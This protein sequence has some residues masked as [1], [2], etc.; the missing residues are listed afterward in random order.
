MRNRAGLKDICILL[1]PNK[2]ILIYSIFLRKIYQDIENTHFLR[3]N[4]RNH[5]VW[6]YITLHYISYMI[7][8]IHIIYILIG[9]VLSLP[10]TFLLCTSFVIWLNLQ[11][12]CAFA[13]AHPF[14]MS[15]VCD[16][17]VLYYHKEQKWDCA[18]K[19]AQDRTNK[20]SYI[21]RL[22]QAQ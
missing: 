19:T 1:F 15:N 22:L 4:R 2:D 10:S 20:I 3:D 5:L 13:V 16:F 11:R 7:D 8:A 9:T 17:L 18:I 14:N 21:M 6:S 12:F